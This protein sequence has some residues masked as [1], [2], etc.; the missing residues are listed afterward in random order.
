LEKPEDGVIPAED[1]TFAAKPRTQLLIR[2]AAVKA[3]RTA[4]DILAHLLV[5]LLKAAR[6]EIRVR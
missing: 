1:H 6:P 3:E 4:A 5:F 2:W